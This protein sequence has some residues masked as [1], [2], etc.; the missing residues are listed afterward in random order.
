MATQPFLIVCTAGI[1]RATEA[2]AWTS[3]FPYVYFMIK[4]FN[5]IPEAQIAYYASML[6]AIF[7]FCEFLSGT[8]W[9]RVSD[10]IGRKKTLLL[11][12]VCGLVAALSFGLSKSIAA[13]V[14][15]RAFGGLFNPNVGVVQTCGVELAG[16]KERQGKQ[17]TQ[18]RAHRDPADLEWCS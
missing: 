6:I 14:A 7:T 16:G 5:D 2:S 9:A 18:P 13:A 15:S 4:A 17:I 12:C 11:G 10:C 1:L 3:I 8:I